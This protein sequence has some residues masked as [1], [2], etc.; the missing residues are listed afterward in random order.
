MII[1]IC[2]KRLVSGYRGNCDRLGAIN[3]N[4]LFWFCSSF[5]NTATSTVTYCCTRVIWWCQLH[6]LFI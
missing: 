5:A 2:H 1:N 6:V 3:S 4:T